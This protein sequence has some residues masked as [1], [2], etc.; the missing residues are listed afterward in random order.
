MARPHPL[1]L[2]IAAGRPASATGHDLAELARSA[3]EHRMTG[4]LWSRVTA[5]EIDGPNE[6]KQGLAAR[7]MRV[8][9]RH[10]RFWVTLPKVASVLGDLGVGCATFKGITTE[11]RW[12]DR[13][14]ERPSTDI[15]LLL[16]PG[17][18]ARA[19]EI[20]EALA[21]DHR[22]ATV[23]PS[24]IRRRFID[25]VTV[26]FDGA[27]IDIH[28]DLLK[29]GVGSRSQL[30]IWERSVVYPIP[31]NRVRVLDPETAL[32]HL[33]VHLNKDRFSRL[34]WYTD[35]LR[36]IRAEAGLDWAHVDRFV[37]TE[38]IEAAV[39]RALEVAFDD[40]GLKA[41]R[42]PRVNGPRAAV[43]SALW[44]PSTRL[45]G[46]V[47]YLRRRHRK[48]WFAFLVRGRQLEAVRWW[49]RQLFPPG[50]L[51][52]YIYPKATGPYLWRL[53]TARFGKGWHSFWQSR[54]E[55]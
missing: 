15:D 39:Y 34:L 43:W 12:H 45:Q 32:V 24:L 33:L 41:P 36:L 54:A 40:V 26:R 35:I 49:W 19:S 46:S 3:H 31:G 28:F 27:L 10:Q 14:G 50:E 29:T 48:Y 38:G 51:L 53:V 13:V 22:L 18:E 9:A 7:D 4:Q 42:H 6:W 23:L 52:A 17:S 11:A 47:G 55:S 37:R 25:T 1:L 2:D 8:R 30:E 44:R 5:G 21:P 20:V 16:P